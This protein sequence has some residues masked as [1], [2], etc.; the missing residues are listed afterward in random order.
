MRASY[1]ATVIDDGGRGVTSYGQTDVLLYSQY[2]G[3][4]R[5]SNRIVDLNTPIGFEVVNV[6]ANGK[7]IP[8][9]QQRITTRVYRNKSVTHYRKNERGYY[10]YVN[11]KQRI[12]VDELKDPRDEYGKFN[13]KPRYSGEHI[14]EVEDTVGKQISRYQFYVAGPLSGPKTQ[15]ADKV[16]T[17]SVNETS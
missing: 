11:E 14:L 2:V 3:L 8:K 5:L 13:Y 9:V 12:L 6:D 10:R 15:Q 16:F 4:R 1:S 17:K 7:S